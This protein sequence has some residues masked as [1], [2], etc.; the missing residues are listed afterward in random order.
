MR[1]SFI[2]LA[3]RNLSPDY[4]KDKKILSLTQSKPKYTIMKRLLLLLSAAL[5][6]FTAVAQEADP[7]ER[8]LKF[9]VRNRKGK[10]MRSLHLTLQLK[11]SKEARSLDRFGNAFFRVSDSDTLMLFTGAGDIYEL[12]MAGLDSLHVVFK[13]ARQIAGVM[14]QRTDGEGSGDQMLDVGYGRVSRDANTNSVS[15]IH[16]DDK[17]AYT[18]LKTFIQGRVAGV[19]F[20]GDQLVI[21]GISSINSGIEALI[22]LDGSPLPNF[23]TANA[24]IS[25]NDVASISVLKDS[26]AA[27]Y[28]SRGANGVVLIT[29]KKGGE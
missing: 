15:Q 10:V 3:V 17:M 19:N 25:P 12:P 22:I 6:V 18:D 8:N 27:I 28:G 2:R 4:I 11:G 29:T 26:S 9:M 23:A 5:F 16:M 20:I 14:R 1:K 24:T 13:N 7:G 21:R